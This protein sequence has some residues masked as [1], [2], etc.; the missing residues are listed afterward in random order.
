M[1]YEEIKECVGFQWDKGN[2]EKN[3]LSHQVSKSE[4]EQLFFNQPLL[5]GH[6]EKHSEVENRFHALGTTDDSR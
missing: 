1:N 4:C 2:S 5:L 3:W 6:D